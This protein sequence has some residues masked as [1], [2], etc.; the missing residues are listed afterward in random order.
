MVR[1][2]PWR[3]AL[4]HQF[5]QVAELAEANWVSKFKLF[6]KTVNR[7]SVLNQGAKKTHEERIR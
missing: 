3:P 4:C 1:V 7:L 2:H 5:R 6:S